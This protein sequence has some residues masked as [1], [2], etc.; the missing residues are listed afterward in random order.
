MA[1]VNMPSLGVDET[2]VTS[3]DAL[4]AISRAIDDFEQFPVRTNGRAMAKRALVNGIEK[5][6][7]AKIA[8]QAAK[9]NG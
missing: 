9:T 2:R 5:L 6:I 3:R 7:D 8:E 4:R 1:E